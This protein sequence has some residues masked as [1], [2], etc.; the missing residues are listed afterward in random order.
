[1]CGACG[2]STCKD[3][4][5]R[6]RAKNL[7]TQV[8]TMGSVA[9]RVSK[10]SDFVFGTPFVQQPFTSPFAR[11]RGQRTPTAMPGT[12]GAP[13]PAMMAP[14]SFTHRQTDNPIPPGPPQYVIPAQG[15]GDGLPAISPDY[16]KNYVDDRLKEYVRRNDPMGLRAVENNKFLGAL[17][18]GL[19]YAQFS[20]LTP[21]QQQTLLKADADQQAQIAAAVSSGATNTINGI[22]NTVKQQ[23]ANDD[24]AAQRE[25]EY[26]MAQLQAQTQKDLAKINAANQPIALQAPQQSLALEKTPTDGSSGSSG[27]GSGGSGS[28]SGGSGMLM[29]AAAAAAAIFFMQGKN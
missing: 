22:F 2:F 6:T 16:V 20:A 14:G 12:D 23:Q 19:S 17:P 15:Q 11:A 7:L 21:D 5:C 3:G 4:L 18:A 26:R 13:P 10:S 29:L 27:S 8:K 24:A 28:S 1:M 25:H 9:G